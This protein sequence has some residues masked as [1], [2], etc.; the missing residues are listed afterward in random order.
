[1][2]ELRT[3]EGGREARD[4]VAV[5]RVGREAVEGARRQP[6]MGTGGEDRLAGEL[7]L[8]PVGDPAPRRYSV[9]PIPAMQTRS[10]TRAEDRLPLAGLS[11]GDPPCDEGGVALPS[12]QQLETLAHRGGALARERFRGVAAERK[13]DRTLVTEADREIE[14]F[15][16]AELGACFPEIGLL[17]EEGTAREGRGRLR[18]V[19]DPIDGTAAFVA[20]LP[21]WTVCIGLLDGGRAVA[22]VV[23]LPAA[24]ETYSAADGTA[25]WNGQRLAPLGE[26]PPAGDR[27]VAAHAKTHLRHEVRYPGK[28]R[29]LGS[30]AYHVVLVAR[31]AAEGALVGHAHVW[32]LAAPGAILDAVSGRYEYLSGGAVDL[33]LL[34]DGRRAPDYIIAGAAAAVTRLRPLFGARA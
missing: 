18:F 34:G 2:P 10:R 29:S 9:S 22:G 25:W 1:M 33:A 31:G 19:I 28:I 32:D 20:G 17:G 30:T 23:H 14:R 3:A 11:T 16:S 4:V 24:G 8:A 26:S 15:F 27:F 7:E 21:T 6:G 13:A 12:R 5:V